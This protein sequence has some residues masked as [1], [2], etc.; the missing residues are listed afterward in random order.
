[1]RSSRRASARSPASSASGRST[2]EIAEALYISPTTVSFHR[3][4]LRR[5]LGLGTRGPR[6]ASHLGQSQA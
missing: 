4:N 1:M 6:L 5:K 2:S 3:K